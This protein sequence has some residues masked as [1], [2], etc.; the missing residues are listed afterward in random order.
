M[1]QGLQVV[2]AESAARASRT[3]LAAAQTPVRELD[4]V[5]GKRTT[6]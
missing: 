1:D 2:R 3:D 6:M 4:A 5:H